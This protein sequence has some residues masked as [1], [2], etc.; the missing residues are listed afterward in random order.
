MRTLTTQPTMTIRMMTSFERAIV[1]YFVAIDGRVL[2]RR[3]RG[4]IR[5]PGRKEVGT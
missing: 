1:G 4:R 3:F 5:E 2:I